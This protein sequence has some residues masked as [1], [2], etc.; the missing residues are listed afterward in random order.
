M[1]K[2]RKKPVVIDAEIY[3][4]GMEDGFAHIDDHDSPEFFGG[5]KPFIKTLEGKMFIS[6]GDFIITGIRGERYPCKSDIFKETYEK[7]KE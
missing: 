1:T 7:V 6:D 4:K 3:K 5:I 2:Y